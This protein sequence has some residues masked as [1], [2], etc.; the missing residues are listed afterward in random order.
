MK[1]V[2]LP[3]LMTPF[4]A[5][6]PAATALSARRAYVL[7]GATLWLLGAASRCFAHRNALAAAHSAISC[8][9]SAHRLLVCGVAFLHFRSH[10]FACSASICE[11][12]AHVMGAGVA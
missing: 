8:R 1:L 2:A 9:G 6:K 11:R 4:A 12:A 5:T 3:S 10:L 7:P